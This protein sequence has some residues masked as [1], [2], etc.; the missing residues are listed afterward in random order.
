[1]ALKVKAVR[2]EIEGLDPGDEIIGV[3]GREVRDQLDLF[4]L[5]ED[6]EPCE[7]LVRKPGGETARVEI[8]PFGFSKAGI[9][10]EEMNF[11]RCRSNCIFCFVDQMPPGMR[12]T[13]YRK[14]DDYRLSFLYGNFITL[15]DIP[16]EEI[17]RIIEYRLS[18]LYVS[19]HSIDNQIREKLFGRPMRNDV[20]KILGRLARSGITIHAQIVLVPGVNDGPSLKETAEKLA[21]LY[22]EV[23]SLALVPVGITKHRKGLP[24]ISPFDAVR[25][26]KVFDWSDAEDMKISEIIKRDER[27]CYL[28]D[29]FYLLAGRK[30]PERGFYGDFDQVSNGVGLSRIFMDDIEKEIDR[31]TEE[32]ETRAEITVVTGELGHQ[33]IMEYLLPRIEMDLPGLKIHLLKVRNRLFGPEVTVSGLLCGRDIIDSINRSVDTGGRIVLPP[34]S[35]NH[36]GSLIDDLTPANI[37]RECGMPVTVARNNFLEP[38]IVGK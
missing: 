15:N 1:M 33:L 26:K 3:E 31:L 2:G 32:G 18:P 9:S 29:E 28:S 16:E 10:F 38:G 11:K 37:R 22:P 4:F 27:F 8:P 34:N 5:L 12:E 14:D 24:E 17:E 30:I 13:L 36:R 20:P 25:A 6:E 19:V 23:K 35:V 21:A 7:I